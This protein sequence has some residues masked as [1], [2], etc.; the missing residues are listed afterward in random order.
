MH[1]ICKAL[2][3]A[4]IA[5][6]A[7]IGISTPSLAASVPASTAPQQPAAPVCGLLSLLPGAANVVCAPAA[8]TTVPGVPNQTVGL[9]QALFG[10]IS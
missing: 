3:T 4:G 5:A 2:V 7:V 8:N 9:L 1:T 6:V 10:V